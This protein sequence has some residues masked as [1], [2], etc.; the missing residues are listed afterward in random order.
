MIRP[1]KEVD[2]V[3]QSDIKEEIEDEEELH[4]IEDDICD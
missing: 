3:I 1:R 2:Q 4:S